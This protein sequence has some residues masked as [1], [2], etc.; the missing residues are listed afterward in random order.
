M[1]LVQNINDVNNTYNTNIANLDSALV[2]FVFGTKEKQVADTK[3]TTTAALN[4]LENL[5]YPKDTWNLFATIIEWA[6]TPEEVQRRIA[7]AKLTPEQQAAFDAGEKQRSATAI[8]EA[9]L[10]GRQLD[11]ELAIAK[12][13]LAADAKANGDSLWIKQQSNYLDMASHYLKLAED[14]N[15]PLATRTTYKA[16]AAE[17]LWM[18]WGGTSTPS[19]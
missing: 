2:T 8:A 14:A 12:A 17:Y 7:L 4:L 19:P 10:K 16:K 6:K 15:I 18:A 5:G 3:A 9:A 1:R 13:R 11:Q